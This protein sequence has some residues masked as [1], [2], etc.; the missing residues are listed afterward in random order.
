MIRAVIQKNEV[1]QRAASHD[2]V[3]SGSRNPTSEPSH[4]NKH[5]SFGSTQFNFGIRPQYVSA[6]GC[7]CQVTLLGFPLLGK[8]VAIRAVSD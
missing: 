2:A 5:L 4:T 1:M 7:V 3:W 8:R 6:V